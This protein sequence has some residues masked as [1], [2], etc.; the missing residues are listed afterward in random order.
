MKADNQPAPD[1]EVTLW[2]GA[3]Q[4]LSDFWKSRKLVLVFLRHLG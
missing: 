1:V 3:T 4:K 2:N